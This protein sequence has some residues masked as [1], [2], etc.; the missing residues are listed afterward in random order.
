MLIKGKITN[1]QLKTSFPLFL[2]K[3][4]WTA[5]EIA[6]RIS[7]VRNMEGDD[8]KLQGNLLFFWDKAEDF[9]IVSKS[10]PSA[11]EF[12]CTCVGFSSLSTDNPHFV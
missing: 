4:A 9:I 12:G 3:N 7:L 1:K 10:P 8:W 11:T 6:W 5:P 2:I